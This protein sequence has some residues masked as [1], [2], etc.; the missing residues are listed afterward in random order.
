MRES[1]EILGVECLDGERGRVARDDGGI[2]FGGDM[3]RSVGQ[4][5]HYLGEQLA[6]QH[7][8]PLFLNERRDFVLNGKFQVGSL[9]R[10]R[11]GA[12]VKVDARQDGKR[13]PCGNALQDDSQC[14]LQFR[15]VDAE[16]H[17]RCLSLAVCACGSSIA[18]P[19]GRVTR[20]A[21]KPRP[22]FA[23]SLR[24][25]MDCFS[26]PNVSRETFGVGIRGR[27]RR[28]WVGGVG[29]WRS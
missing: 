1:G 13:R 6:R 23:S 2:P 18:Q 20:G 4:V 8:A 17:N 22:S 15:L 5:L 24:I 28:V 10:E 16:L 9:E 19:R 26:L 25:E 11:V 27:G 29:N 3:H 12:G 7:A 14:V 21:A